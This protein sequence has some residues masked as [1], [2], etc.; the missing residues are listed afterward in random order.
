MV[1]KLTLAV[2]VILAAALALT[3]G[4]VADDKGAGEMV[5]QGGKLG[6]VPFPHHRHHDALGDC[7]PCHNLFPKVAGVIERL[8]VEGKLQKKKVMK[9]CRGCHK[10]KASKEEKTG[11]TSCKD[12]HKKM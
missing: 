9:Q 7:A 8:K 12:C 11:P 1:K 3:L 10:E 4:A 6:N 2:L 5:L